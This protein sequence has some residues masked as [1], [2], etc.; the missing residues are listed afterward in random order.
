MQTFIAV[1]VTAILLATP[2]LAVACTLFPDDPSTVFRNYDSIFLAHP[3]E[4]SPS[5][6]EIEQLKENVSYQQT[7]TWHVIRSWKGRFTDG[8]TFVTVRK[9]DRSDPCSGWGV[10]RGY[11]PKIF[12]SLVDSSPHAYD[13][14]PVDIAILQLNALKEEYERTGE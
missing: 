12:H 3:L 10:T 1:L 2:K 13:A 5:P 11:E 9:I 4:I 6:D 8:D 7:V 14:F